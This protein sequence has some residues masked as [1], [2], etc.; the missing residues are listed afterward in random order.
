MGR[1]T[2]LMPP[3]SNKAVRDYITPADS[4]ALIDMLRTWLGE[5]NIAE[6]YSQNVAGM[7]VEMGDLFNY[8]NY[9]TDLRGVGQTPVAG[10]LPPEEEGDKPSIVLD[11]I[12][13]DYLNKWKEMGYNSPKKGATGY[14]TST[15]DNVIHHEAIGHGLIEAMNILNEMPATD[16]KNTTPEEDYRRELFPAFIESFINLQHPEDLGAIWHKDD[17]YGKRKRGEA[18]YENIEAAEE[19]NKLAKESLSGL[20]AQIQ[21]RNVGSDIESPI[22]SSFEDVLGQVKRQEKLRRMKAI[23]LKFPPMGDEA[24]D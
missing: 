13:Y 5:P 8:L 7:P 20:L 3:D 24:W 4:T 16:L 21:S 22:G 6:I 11:S 17:V 23:G 9:A 1:E 19:L 18:V 12:M 10:F 14:P 2:L 15:I